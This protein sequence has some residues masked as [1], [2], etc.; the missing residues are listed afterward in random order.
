MQSINLENFI[1]RPLNFI[2][3][4]E[5][6]YLSA[7]KDSPVKNKNL[8][9]NCLKILNKKTSRLFLSLTS[10]EDFESIIADAHEELPPYIGV[11]IPIG[12]Y[13]E[14]SRGNDILNNDSNEDFLS[15]FRRLNQSLPK[16]LKLIPIM[17]FTDNS[18]QVGPTIFNLFKEFDIPFLVI[19]VDEIP[20]T[21]K[22]DQ[23]KSIFNYLKLRGFKKKIYF[24]FSNPNIEEWNM[25]TFNTFSGMRMMHIDLSNKC[26]HSCVFCGVWGP[27]FLENEL[28]NSNGKLTPNST[29][30]LNRQMPIEIVSKILTEMPETIYEIQFG[31]V[32]DP[33]T[34]PNWLEIITK[35]RSRGIRTE[36]LTNLDI[37]DKNKL[38]TLSDY[39]NTHYGVKLYI[40]LSA[41][42]K[43]TYHIVRP[44]QA[45]T[46][47]E[48]VIDNIK[49]LNSFKSSEHIGANITLLHVINS[50]NF[51]EMVKMVEM[52]H[53]LKARVWLKPLEVHS[54]IHRKFEIQL[55]QKDEY[56][57]ILNDAIALSKKLDVELIYDSL[58]YFKGEQVE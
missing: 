50:L 27:D 4:N 13:K 24:P 57:K 39:S 9:R 32:G 45:T 12:D 30:F 44:R 43:E 10:V 11:T 26:T 18:I 40:N 54:E 23:I 8:L 21:M 47:F 2:Q 48:R 34:H 1:S 42:T 41:G 31:G 53:N 22:I 49:F 46:V 7:P 55:N 58:N 3:S 20:T 5:F 28:K 56:L 14:F 15:T 36:I 19:N 37:S 51:H 38:K 6:V 25:K 29:E 16:N 35:F 33:L 17:D 52:G